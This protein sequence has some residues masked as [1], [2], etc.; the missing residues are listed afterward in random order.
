LQSITSYA[1]TPP[2]VAA[3]TF[4]Y[5]EKNIPIH[6]LCASEQAYKNAPYWNRFTNYVD[7]LQN[8]G[9]T[10]AETEN[11][12]LFLNP[13]SNQLQIKNYQLKGAQ[14]VEIIDVLGRILQSTVANQQQSEIIIDV[15]HLTKGMYFVR[16]GNWRGKF[17]VN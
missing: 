7:C 11:T 15:S 17:V 9:L 12:T 4:E 14:R 10:E 5:L 2:T 6:V 16:I 13:S 3:S 1:T 8:V